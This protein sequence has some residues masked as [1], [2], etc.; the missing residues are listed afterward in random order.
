MQPSLLQRLSLKSR[1]TL[2]TLSIFLISLWSLSLYAARML[3]QDLEQVL[4][5]QQFA[6]VSLVAAQL[7]HDFEIRRKALERVANASGAALS[8][9]SAL[10][11]SHL[12]QNATLVELFNFGVLAYNAEGTAVAEV[13]LS[14]G[15]VGKSY[16]DNDTVVAAL[17]EGRT[18]LSEVHLGKVLRAPVFGI[19]APIRSAQGH[20]IGAL[21][22]V[23]DLGKPN[24][25]D[26][27]FGKHYA[28]PGGYLLVAPKQ[29]LIVAATDSARSM[30]QLPPR[31]VIDAMDKSIDGHH[32]TSIVVNPHKVEMLVSTKA[33]PDV[34]WIVV[35]TLPTDEAFAP[36]R[37]LQ[38][39][40]LQATL[41]LTLL[42]GAL[43][44]WM[45]RRQLAPMQDTVHALVKLANSD[46]TPQAL[47]VHRPDE[48][49]E[50]V[51][52]FNRLL[53]NLA[54]RE[55]ALTESANQY[56]QLVSDLAVGVIIQ[57]PSS[58]I[59]MSNHLAL[60]LLGL[61]LDQLLGKTSLDPSWDV[62]HE[63]GSAFPGHTHP[64][65][66]AIA[67]G[68]PVEHV[69]MGVFRPS[70][71]SR[72]WLLVTA[73]PQFHADGSLQ[74]V[75]VTFSDISKRKQAEMALLKSEEF[76]S[77]I[78][79]S[80]T[81]E[82]AVIDG[83]GTIQTVNEGWQRFWLSA[84]KTQGAN[85]KPIGVGSNY[86]AVC[87]ASDQPKS[88]DGRDAYAG[89]RAVLDGH[90][91]NFSMEYRCDSPHDMRWFAM[92]V[93]PL[94]KDVREGAVI[95]HTDITALKL[96]AQHE[97]HR[98]HVLERMAAG[99]PLREIL[100]ALV[101]G[102]EQLQHHAICSILMVSNDGRRL[103][104]GVGP[105]LPESYN[106]ALE[107]IEIGIGV[108]SCGTAAFTGQLV[109]V[110]D[111]ATHPYWLP[112]RH[113]AENA[114]LRS[115]WSQPIFA[116]D[117][118]VLG[119][120]AIYHAQPHTPTAADLSL[121]EQSAKLASIAIEKSR[122]TEQ[123]RDSEAHF[124][125]L[126]EQ[127]S[128]VIWR[129]DRNHV[130]TYISPADE[131]LRGC[132]ANE[133][134]GQHVSSLLTDEGM[135]TFKQLHQEA[136][137]RGEATEAMTFELQQ[138][139]KDGRLIWTEVLSTPERDAQGKITGYHGVTREITERKEM[140]D[141]VKELAFFDPLTHLPNRRLLD[142]R[143][144]Q[145]MASS[146]RTG[147][148][149]ALIFLDLDNFKPLND[150]HGHDAG[151]LLLVEVAQRLKACVR[152]MD[153][154]VRI[155]GDEFVVMLSELKSDRAESRLQAGVIAEKVRHA[156]AQ[157]YNLT[158]R[159]E[160]LPD[161]TVE[162]HCS[163][164]LGVALFVNHDTNQTNVLKWA[165]A[166]M[167][168]AKEAGRNQIRFHGDTN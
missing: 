49:G 58:E 98:S 85:A 102:V 5:Q 164:S 106:A 146:S 158:V 114:G 123:L 20:V 40:L 87:S 41:L 153:T 10:M 23:I 89:I 90:L 54:E 30:E 86:L 78:L 67:T 13:P 11:Q 21:S 83:Q 70:T 61:T 120:F 39:R 26:H 64:A 100:E 131:R 96:A 159:R 119:T 62:I 77:T 4:G 91:P 167:Y 14:A 63:D 143:L 133:V 25:L 115:C 157:P 151:D 149:G 42:A 28:Q 38:Q 130:F 147:R 148:Y 166:A 56:R 81:A 138:R 9:G 34:G 122:M 7:N 108:G 55:A 129:Q 19:S 68:Q 144:K 33:M 165:D 132:C 94:G 136:E 145:T 137:Q 22:G 65:S 128:D 32:G 101:M 31:G 141:R 126:T 142:D 16:L 53:Q 107:G 155:G 66:R 103:E 37:M 80:L 156:L 161:I 93:V 27:V 92:T 124:R 29:R 15:R 105:S 75:V 162:H 60:E 52:G 84:V 150:S 113:L 51:E 59:L 110:E 50:L 104:S 99:R 118:R 163:A 18:T 154:V 135:N 45:L 46:Q 44:W 47:P 127:V 69:V 8:A 140:Q 76:K 160:G 116:A 139:C 43:T 36:I 6:T 109:V 12:E 125:L 72:V 88:S 3:R 152:E 24:F 168:A 73:K 117:G 95:S 79:N 48:L 112:Y 82:I 97:H 111:I 134:I 71:Q 1:V 2:F 74:Q 121:I 17:K 35:A 57:S